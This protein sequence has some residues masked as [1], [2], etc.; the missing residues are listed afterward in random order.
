LLAATGFKR[1]RGVLLL[2]VQLPDG[3]PGTIRADAT[4]VF[5]DRTPTTGEG[6]VLSVE[7]IGRLRALVL[8]QPRR[9]RS[10]GAGQTAS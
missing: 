3:T 4:D 9:R 1:V 8:A 2:V 5:G 10:R 7:G 6:T